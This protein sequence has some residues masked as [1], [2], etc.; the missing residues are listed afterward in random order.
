MTQRCRRS[1]NVQICLMFFI[2]IH[3]L[4]LNGWHAL[5]RITNNH[6]GVTITTRAVK[7]HFL[8]WMTMMRQPTKRRC[9]CVSTLIYTLSC[10]YW[11]DKT[12]PDSAG[13]RVESF[14]PS[15]VAGIDLPHQGVVDSYSLELNDFCRDMLPGIYIMSDKH[16]ELT[17]N[18]KDVL[19]I[20]KTL[21]LNGS[22]Q[23]NTSQFLWPILGSISA[24]I[25][26][27]FGT[28]DY[29]LSHGVYIS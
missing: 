4:S 10:V 18:S 11:W 5:F 12:I 7:R 20:T 2:Y 9:S 22:S 19:C 13:P 29:V 14:H 16:S 25:F 21:P 24:N 6:H 17:E 3:G 23:L 8:I 28:V 15:F 27:E 26:C 1:T